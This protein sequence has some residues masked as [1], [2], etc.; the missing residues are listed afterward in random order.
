MAT[1]QDRLNALVA[2]S[3]GNAK[4]E[5]TALFDNIENIDANISRNYDGFEKYNNTLYPVCTDAEGKCMELITACQNG[6]TTQCLT[7]MAQDNTYTQSLAKSNSNNVYTST[8]I[9]DIVTKIK[10]PM[11][12]VTMSVKPRI[13]GLVHLG[14]FL[15]YLKFMEQVKLGFNDEKS[16][17]YV[18]L[19]A[20]AKTIAELKLVSGY[21]TDKSLRV[22]NVNDGS[23]SDN[24]FKYPYNKEKLKADLERIKKIMDDVTQAYGQL[25][26]QQNS[27]TVSYKAQKVRVLTKPDEWYAKMSNSKDAA[28]KTAVKNLWDSQFKGILETIWSLCDT[29]PEILNPEYVFKEKGPKSSI[30]CPGGVDPFGIPFGRA[31][32]T[33]ASRAVL[34]CIDSAIA[35]SNNLRTLYT[36]AAQADGSGKMK[37]LIGLPM[38]MPIGIAMRGLSGGGLMGVSDEVV[39]PITYPELKFQ[40]L[41]TQA[42]ANENDVNISAIEEAVKKQLDDHRKREIKSYQ[43]KLVLD[44]L[45]KEINSGK[46]TKPLEISKVTE[47]TT[48]VHENLVKALSRSYR[49]GRKCASA[50]NTVLNEVLMKLKENGGNITLELSRT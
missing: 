24:D 18:Q 50:N 19:R 44:E 42:L 35:S 12:E 15:S 17:H 36:S 20:Q 41:K 33:T 1:L 34:N 3:N 43:L 4:D 14:T 49:S 37:Q 28:E 27:D 5:I 6:S 23:F 26:L 16:K 9:T 30:S 31:G 7:A 40:W 45:R 10:W 29:Y 22:A 25:K 32:C 11:K 39:A 38:P 21:D 48:K 2:N 13:V 47:M 8:L 46:I